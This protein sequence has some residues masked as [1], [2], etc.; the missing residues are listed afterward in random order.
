LN[1]SPLSNNFAILKKNIGLRVAVE[2]RDLIAVIFLMDTFIKS[3]K[4]LSFSFKFS[5]S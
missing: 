1:S 4:P 5:P 3:R 2:V